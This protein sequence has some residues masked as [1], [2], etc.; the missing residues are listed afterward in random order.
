MVNPINALMRVEIRVQSNAA[1]REIAALQSQVAKLQGQLAKTS[2]VANAS[3]L[4]S[5]AWGAALRKNG[6]QIQWMGRQ[7]S[8]NFSL[9]LLAAGG[10]ATKWALDNEK[11]MTRVQKVY[12]DNTMSA[13][14]V[15]SETEA[16]GRA[17]R[18]LS[19]S[20]GVAQEEVINIG[21]E[22]AAA[23]AS[24][25]ALAKATKLTMQ[26]MVLGEL[27]AKEAT[28]A[29]IA[30]QAQYGLQ[31]ESNKK[32]TMDLT[33]VIDILNM[34]ENQTGASM[35]GLVQGLSRAAGSA[36]T[37]GI[38]VRHLA[39]FM[40]ALTPAAGTA[41]NAGNGLKTI[42]SRLLAP[43][44]EA[45]EL[46]DKIG[47]NTESV[48]WQAKNGSQRLETMA[49][50][51]TKL[52]G[53][54][55]SVVASYVA[56]RY[57]INRFDVL[58][59][60]I[61]N[62]NGYYQ[63]ALNSTSSEQDN[64]KQKVKELNK[65][66]DSNPQKLKIMTTMIKN[67]FA[68]ALQQTLPVILMFVGLVT[69][70]VRKFSELSPGIQKFII[71]S[72]GVLAVAGPI[73]QLVGATVLLGGAML[74]TAQV[75]GGIF[76]RGMGLALLSMKKLTAGAIATAR[77][78]TIFAP[79]MTR[80]QMVAAKGAAIA[81]TAFTY[82]WRGAVIATSFMF[83]LI[84]PAIAA[85]GPAVATASAAV[86]ALVPLGWAVAII[87]VIALI[88][89]MR[90]E[91]AYALG[92][93]PGVFVSVFKA[94]ISVVKAAAKA[95]YEWFS[96]LNPWATHS[97]SLVQSVTTG[98][99]AIEAQYK[100][101]SKI[102]SAFAQAANALARFKSVAAGLDA[103]ESRSNRKEVAKAMPSNLG[104]Y[105]ALA[106][107]LAGLNSQLVKS[108]QA[109]KKQQGVVDS[110][111]KK[112]DAANAAVD[113]QR[114]KLDGLEG[115]LSNLTAKYDKHK[116]ALDSYA[117]APIKGMGKMEDAIFANEMA[118][119]KLRLEILKWE[120]ANGSVDDMK[121]TMSSLAGDIEKL[122][123]EASE[124]QRS[125]AGS[126]VLSPIN[127]QIKAMEAQYK[128]IGK[129][130]NN[131]PVNKAQKELEKLQ[132]QGEIMDLEKSITFDPLR[133]EIDKLVNSQKELSYDEIVAGIKREK[134]A[135]DALEPQIGKVNKQIQDQ[136]LVLDE[137]EKKRDSVQAGYDRESAKLSRV[138]AAYNKIRDAIDK[139]TDAMQRME[140]A[141]EQIN[142]AREAKKKDKSN[143]LDQFERA[144]K[145]S[146]ADVG[147]AAKI[148]REGGMGDQSKLIDQWTKD[149]QNEL[150]RSMSKID[151]SAAFG[152]V[153]EDFK[154]WLLQKYLALG[155]N[156]YGG[157]K[158][159]WN[160]YIKPGIDWVWLKI[161]EIWN[162]VLDWIGN[163]LKDMFSPVIRAISG[164]IDWFQKLY[165]TLIGNSIIPDLVNGIID[166]FGKLFEPISKAVS[167]VVVAVTDFF[168]NMVENIKWWW[169]VAQVA[170]TNAGEWILDAKNGLL[171]YFTRLPGKVKEQ[172]D[173]LKS[174][175]KDWWDNDARPWIRDKIGDWI[176]DPAAGFLGFF[177]KLP[178][179]VKEQFDELKTKV[180]KWW[181]ET[182]QPWFRDT[183]GDWFVN[184]DTGLISII[185]GLPGKVKEQ[186]E[187]LK[188]NVE[189][190][191]DE[192]GKPW[193][194]NS[195]AGWFLSTDEKGLLGIMG[196]IPGKIKD[197]FVGFKKNISDW[198]DETGKPWFKNKFAGW[199]TDKK[200]GLLSF[201]NDIPDKIGDIFRRIP[202]KI[203]DAL[204][205]GI[206]LINQLI[207]KVNSMAGKIGI[208]V[209][210]GH[211]PQLAAGGQIPNQR[212]G[213][214]FR[215]NR[216][217]AI[218]GEGSSQY[219][220]YVIPTDP[221]YRDRALQLVGEV[222]SLVSGKTMPS[223]KVLFNAG[224]NAKDRKNVG[225]PLDAI[226]DAVGWLKGKARELIGKAVKE[227][228][229]FLDNHM[230]EMPVLRSITGKF[231]DKLIDWIMGKADSADGQASTGGPASGNGPS[232]GGWQA[233]VSWMRNA[234]AKFQI[235]STTGGQHA[236]GSYH[237]LGRAVDLDSF[238]GRNPGPGLD[239]IYKVAVG[240][241]KHWKELIYNGPASGYGARSYYNGSPHNYG[242]ATNAAH[243]NHVHIALA[244][245]GIVRKPTRALIGEAGP[246]A[247]IPL[248]KMAQSIG[249]RELVP[250]LASI[251]RDVQ[252]FNT[253]VSSIVTDRMMAVA[254]KRWDAATSPS[255][256]VGATVHGDRGTTI[257]IN[258][259]LSFPNIS[260]GDDAKKFIENLKA[261]G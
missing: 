234:G 143:A 253:T 218:V 108:D 96:Y 158:I 229:S 58:M 176:L 113:K 163:R 8:Y 15:K 225:G 130:V 105:D 126:D 254:I 167:S 33:K 196:G 171:G 69:N 243:N 124:L 50:A 68:E 88:E 37:A 120:E 142:Q 134:A 189:K 259:D 43:T 228:V 27:D 166:W 76:T 47:L 67:E 211:I 22:W 146:Y 172:F 180:E 233:I 250:H 92:Q 123:G 209:N 57:Q 144:G 79:I 21:A 52:N 214:G 205:S 141:S 30:I 182:A 81:A 54:Q 186:F 95:V 41:A 207:D 29:L 109:V 162:N 148:G 60:D 90:D 149:L 140:Q 94:V 18:A 165:D 93:L 75:A 192:T 112:L 44:K 85:I 63:K 121:N 53:A 45:A 147:G 99:N 10:L 258:G 170:L 72:L 203:K 55:K 232:G 117:N 155:E 1:R 131:S 48:A 136:K 82:A 12:G 181:K 242:A 39:A 201:L 6:S 128:K 197:V 161:Q 174:K 160:D 16:L 31:V 91:I 2:A 19:D 116:E 115:K 184:S 151:M 240:N 24:G 202:G 179:K 25:L 97:P 169:N 168:K 138:E 187:A 247:V 110:W 257:N 154:N 40:A 119:K 183:L 260:D 5:P 177:V 230:P 159:L 129:T 220:E 56:G 208:N 106:R 249:L 175:I 206:N 87:A 164:V 255:D 80:A 215:T 118:Q 153:W 14:Q 210:F 83:S 237:Y 46:M 70:L 11:A 204:N 65:V 246:E 173:D 231:K 35:Q 195:F 193:F 26:T 157:Y 178:G 236:P 152:R 74:G 190:W 217:R 226:G 62:K 9:P 194:K 7:I 42:F 71:V 86:A 133:R 103:A 101:A 132:R 111:K 36:R 78:F 98:F 125:G 216:A 199:F 20:M 23:G 34:V 248:S 104:V 156:L 188:D 244:E 135:M 3:S 51:F 145:G 32:G 38:D 150:N 49:K 223:T 239:Q 73:I 222:S 227:A 261:L 89:A 77:F 107:A 13:K 235:T 137:L 212:V 4:T 198:W 185:K 191:W 28:E 256:A 114:D 102:G 221:K 100:R 61:I 245:G 64:Y 251:S 252:S 238:D 84:A 224:A 122:K 59:R 66:L 213:S 17:F 219:P 241:A 139:V 127:D 200:E